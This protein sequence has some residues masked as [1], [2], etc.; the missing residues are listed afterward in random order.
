[1]VYLYIR[2]TNS[3][4]M[5]H[6]VSAFMRSYGTRQQPSAQSQIVLLMLISYRNTLI[7]AFQLKMYPSCLKAFLEFFEFTGLDKF[8]IDNNI[9]LHL[10]TAIQNASQLCFFN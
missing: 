5:Q 3:L 7:A 10:I 1:M 2:K 6:L 4:R 8:D 9:I